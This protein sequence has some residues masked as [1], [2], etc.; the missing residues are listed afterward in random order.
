[1]KRLRLRRPSPGLVVAVIAL[2]CATAGGATAATLITGKQIK[3]SSITGVDVKNKSLTKAD[4]KGSVTG[5][6]GAR[7]PAG[8][9]G[10]PGSTAFGSL[11]YVTSGTVANPNGT[12]SFAEAVCNSDERVV[13][14]G[15]LTSGAFVADQRVN[16]SFPSD[17]TGNALGAFG[18][19][20][21]A[22]FVDNHGT[23]T[24]NFE[25]WA[26]CAK[27]TAVT[28]AAGKASKR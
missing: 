27:A 5:P 21:W 8:P 12:Q 17:G 6:P 15:V 7:G 18:T 16:S 9:Q 28:K 20:G 25:V 24:Q 11:H 3:N 14:G 13:G 1:M 26:I 19:A 22:A 10:P 4:F 23:D 2:V